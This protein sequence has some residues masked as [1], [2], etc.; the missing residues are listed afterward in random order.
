MAADGIID[1]DS[2]DAL[3]DAYLQT[4]GKYIDLWAFLD[5]T[6]RIKTNDPA[7]DELSSGPVWVD[8]DGASVLD[9][10]KEQ[11]A[12]LLRAVLFL[13]SDLPYEYPRGSLAC[14]SCLLILVT[15]GLYIP[16]HAWLNRVE[17]REH[18]AKWDLGDLSV[19][20]F[21]RK[22][23]FDAEYAKSCPFARFKAA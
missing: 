22:S 21:F 12:N 5:I 11:R 9:P 6:K 1:R 4:L 13:R 3:A 20:P 10:T 14:G 15:A 16:I 18:K 23:D 2:R 8:S 19:W 7:V 17:M